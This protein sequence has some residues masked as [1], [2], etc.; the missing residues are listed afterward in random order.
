MSVAADWQIA[1]RRA[2]AV[3]ARAAK[4]RSPLIDELVEMLAELLEEL[5]GTNHEAAAQQRE[6]ELARGELAAAR[7]SHRELL[8][9]GGE[10]RV[11]SN[12]RGEVIAASDAACGL[13]GVPPERIAGAS[14]WKL[15]GAAARADLRAAKE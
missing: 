12:R 1:H 11:L 3:L 2:A 8:E 10:A 9:L 5:Q 7:Q 13:L 4:Q 15:L 14:M 6:L